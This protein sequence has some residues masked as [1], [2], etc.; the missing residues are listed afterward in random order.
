MQKQKSDVNI[1]GQFGLHTKNMTRGKGTEGRRESAFFFTSDQSASYGRNSDH[2]TP[3]R[4]L[5][6]R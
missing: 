1:F 3:N 2:E 4:L 5:G 6:S